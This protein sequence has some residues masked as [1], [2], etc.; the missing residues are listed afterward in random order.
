MPLPFTLLIDPVPADDADTDPA[1]ADFTGTFHEIDSSAPALRV[2]ELSTQRGDGIFET[3][4]VVNG[5]PLEV[6]PHIK[7]LINSAQICELPVPNAKQWRAAIAHAVARVPH[8][9]ELALKLVL[10][11]GVEHGPAPTAWLHATA[12][13][14]FHGIRQSGVKVATLDRGYARG[15]AE[16]APWL[17]MGAKTLSYAVNMA[18]LREAKRRGADDAIFLTTDGFVMEGPTSSVIIRSGGAFVTP[19]PSGAILHGTTQ[20]SLFEHLEAEGEQVQY[21]DVTV[22]ELRGA[23]AAWLVS[24]VRLAVAVTELDGRPFPVD[25]ERTRAFNAYLLGRTA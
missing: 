21:R 10:S 19:A 13:Q 12:A 24:S 20:Q 6:E 1:E 14:D 17:L 11:R 9:G 23:D 8:E 5:H 7:R 2:A 18:A 4:S 15:V 22:E 3:L 25:A 16:R